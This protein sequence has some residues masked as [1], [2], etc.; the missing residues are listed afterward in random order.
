M[1]GAIHNVQYGIRGGVPGCTPSRSPE[2]LNTK[3]T[4]APAP[5]LIRTTPVGDVAI[6]L[7]G[8]SILQPAKA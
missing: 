1:G 2:M 6:V 7:T 8:A 4:S 5:H 3:E